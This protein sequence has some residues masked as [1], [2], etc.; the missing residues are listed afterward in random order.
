LN[1]TRVLEGI[2]Y[3]GTEDFR[4]KHVILKSLRVNANISVAALRVASFFASCDLLLLFNLLV[5]S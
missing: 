5:V 1:L 2:V 4:L 3:D